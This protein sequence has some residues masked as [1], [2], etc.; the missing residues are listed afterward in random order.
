MW[1]DRELFTTEAQRALSQKKYLVAELENNQKNLCDLCVSVVN[2]LGLY[3]MVDM[4]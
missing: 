2:F 3:F 4:L 1:V